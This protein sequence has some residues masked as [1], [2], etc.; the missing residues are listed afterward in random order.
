VAREYEA[1]VG[2]IEQMLAQIWAEV[3][4]LER[5]GRYDHFFDLGGHSLLVMKMVSRLR[6]ALGVEVGVTDIFSRPVL[7]EFAQAVKNAARSELPPITS[8]PRD[9]PLALSFAQQRLW[10]VAQMEGMSQAY[11]IP[12]G[13]RLTGQLD[14]QA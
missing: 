9:Q 13:L 11:H 6:L 4:R 10:F 12:V 8:I 5:V 3:L 7:A 2:E 14:R 1:P